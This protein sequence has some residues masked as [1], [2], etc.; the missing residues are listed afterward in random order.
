[1]RI[2]DP[3]CSSLGL[4]DVQVEDMT[5]DFGATEE[6]ILVVPPLTDVAGVGVF[7]AGFCPY[8]ITL[9]ELETGLP[10]EHITI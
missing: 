8:Y 5:I 9:L 3:V 2:S 7:D 10:F 1:M 6:A 4:N